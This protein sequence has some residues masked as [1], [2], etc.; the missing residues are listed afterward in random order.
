MHP[1]MLSLSIFLFLLVSFRV[2]AK[3]IIDKVD[4]PFNPHGNRRGKNGQ[5]VFP[6]KGSCD[7]DQEK[8]IRDDI[9]VAN[10]MAAGQS[11]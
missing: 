3:I 5:F 9:D 2:T 8:K 4:D 10:G 11:L 7:A 6:L 1:T